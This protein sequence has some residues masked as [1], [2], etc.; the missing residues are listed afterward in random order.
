MTHKYYNKSSIA[1]Q[2]KM[3]TK[4]PY[5]D[6]ITEINFVHASSWWWINTGTL[7]HVGYVYVMFNTYTH[8]EDKKVLLGYSHSTKVVGIRDVEI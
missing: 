3:T 6:L 8:T 1:L 4:E 2:A 7:F 5:M